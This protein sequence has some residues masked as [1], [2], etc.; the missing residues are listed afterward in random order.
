MIGTI[1]IPEV[2][3]DTEEDEYV[4]RLLRFL[5]LHISTDSPQF[6]IDVTEPTS[7]KDAVKTVIRTDLL[8]QLRTSLHRLGPALIAE[9]GKDIQHAPGTG[10]SSGTNTP[11]SKSTSTAVPSV[12]KPSVPATSN[13]GAHTRPSVNTST[14]TSTAEFRTSAAELYATFTDP[15]RLAAL[16]RSPPT[17]FEGARPGARFAL[18]GGGVTGSYETLE[19]PRRIVQRWRLAHWPEGHYSG[20]ELVFDQNDVDH[21]TVMRV[22]WDAVPV[23]EEDS[24]R[25]KWGEYYVRSLKTVFGFGTI[26]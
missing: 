26:L 6:E 3:H 16:T 7:S 22:A 1:T 10:P 24:T 23:G 18:F 13:A 9:H 4:V 25:D 5:S 12:A 11:L 19:P 8:P 21:V 17:L 2:A 20:L 15:G 14:L